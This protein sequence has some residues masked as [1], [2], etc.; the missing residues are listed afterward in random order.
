MKALMVALFAGATLLFVSM[1]EAQDGAAVGAAQTSIV[2]VQ[3]VGLVLPDKEYLIA[4]TDVVEVFVLRMPEVSR[5]YRVSAEGTIDMP[6][7]GQIKA[8]KQTSHQLAA[9]I[10]KSLQGDYLV[11]PQVSVVVKQANRLYFIQG[12]VRSPGVFT[13][14]GRP[15]LLEL[16]SIAGGLNPTYATTAF[17]MHNTKPQE[18]DADSLYELRTANLSRL[19]RGELTEN[20]TIEPG[21]IVHIPPSDVF[22]VAGEVKHPGSFALSE[23][24]T[25]R[26]AISVA[27][28]TTAVASPTKAIIFREGAGG[29]KT[30]IPVDITAV[31]RGREP[32]V[33]IMANDIIVVPNSKAKSALL[34]VMNSFGANIALGAA[35]VIIP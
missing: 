17:I 18:R 35:R 4:S 32:D 6:F 23:G 8:E 19:L 10:A 27:E 25:L 16:I 1:S 26:R 20:V 9:V 28:N 7:V 12:A 29:Q 15:T 24:T 21:D 34:P 31:M 5:E 11:D 3:S 13:I 30:E 22:F 14:E 2:P 33:R